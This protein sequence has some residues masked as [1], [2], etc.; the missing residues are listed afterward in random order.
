[1]QSSAALRAGIESALGG[2]LA[3]HLRWR[4]RS[5]PE[6][7]PIGIAE[8][9]G[10]AGGLPRGS[11]TEIH[12]LASSGRTSLVAAILAAAAGREEICAYVDS[13]DVF[14]PASAEAAGVD[15][16]RLLWIRCGGN[17]EHALKAAD[18]LI[19]NGGFGL[20]VLD[21]GDISTQ[22]ARRIP[23]ASWFRLR[24]SIENTPTVMV[25]LE[26]NHTVK[27]CA[28]LAI[29]MR[30]ERVIWSGAPA[31]SRLLRGARLNA[32]LP[33][34]RI[35]RKSVASERTAFDVSAVR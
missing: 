31:C 13:S 20:V 35:S 19:Q 15:L 17:P 29:E 24:R 3:A 26:R 28:A 2:R 12:G 1:M 18:L 25:L 16:A 32:V 5:A 8:L 10:L 33:D 9:D 30:R 6:R 22:I 7:V 27:S 23:L 21:L 34:A 14:D 11:I 4:D